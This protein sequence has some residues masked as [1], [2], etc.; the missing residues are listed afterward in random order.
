ML[1]QIAPDMPG[2]ARYRAVT[3]MVI[4]YGAGWSDRN[5]QSPLRRQAPQF[6]YQGDGGP[7]RAVLSQ[8]EE[9]LRWTAREAGGGSPKGDLGR[10]SH[11]S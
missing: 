2:P 7:T 10:T 11:V 3:S 8:C 6:T 9:G 5:A 4:F 1:M